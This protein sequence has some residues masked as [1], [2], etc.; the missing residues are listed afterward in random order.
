MSPSQEAKDNKNR[1][2]SI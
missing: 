1:E 2:Y